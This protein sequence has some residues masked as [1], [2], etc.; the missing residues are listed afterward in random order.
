[1]CVRHWAL[2][3]GLAIAVNLAPALLD[4][5]MAWQASMAP[6]L[7]AS[8]PRPAVSDWRIWVPQWAL[9]ALVMGCL[10][11]AEEGDRDDR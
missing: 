11:W 1:M 5:S 8:T 7:E 6:P 4:F 3:I 10:A 9:I 2:A